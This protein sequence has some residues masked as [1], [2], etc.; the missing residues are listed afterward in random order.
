M[1]AKQLLLVFFLLASVLSAG[2]IAGLLHPAAV[3]PAITPVAGAAQLSDTVIS[4]SFEESSMTVRLP[5]DASVYYGAKQADKSLYLYE[6]LSEDEW[7]PIYYSAFINDTHQDA[8]YT[9]LLQELRVI[10]D[11]E[12]LDS[13][14]YL[15]LIAV[16]VQSLPYRS[17]ERLVEPKFPIETFVDGNGD[18]DD[19]SLLLSALLAREGYDVALFYFTDE[20]HMAVGINC[21]GYG[22]R[23]TGYAYIEATNTSY[24]GIPPATLDGG[25]KIESAPVVIPVGGGMNAY[26][27]CSETQAIA[28]AITLTRSRVETLE[29][30]LT[31]LSRELESTNREIADLRGEMDALYAAKKTAQYNRLVPR[32]NSL[33]AEYNRRTEVYN[34]LVKESRMYADI[35]NYLLIH[36]HNRQGAYLWLA[37]KEYLLEA[38][39]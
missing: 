15:E 18:C 23:K 2:C 3:P 33:V 11:R 13:D 10:R 32:Y 26:G 37:E 21:T 4:F 30:E 17:D 19:K 1:Q 31:A 29:P 25:K 9:D 8:F 36:A 39:Q 34:Q 5:V 35:H 7:L 6:N 22:Y 27:R 24:V 38:I 14:R 20:Q 16:F 28:D 12:S